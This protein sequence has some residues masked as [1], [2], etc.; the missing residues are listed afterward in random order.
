MSILWQSSAKAVREVCKLHR[1]GHRSLRTYPGRQAGADA[2]KEARASGISLYLLRKVRA[3]ADPKRGYAAEELIDLCNSIHFCWG[4]F[5]D[6]GASFGRTHVLRLVGVPKAGGRRA[7]IQ[8]AMFENG[9]STAE[10][11]NEV[12]RRYGRRGQGGRKGAIGTQVAGL[13]IRLD[14]LCQSWLRFNEQLAARKE[15][16]QRPA[17]AE[18]PSKVRSSV[19]SI[20]DNMRRLRKELNAC[21]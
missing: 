6:N 3:F 9:W 5:V 4:A 2:A 1:I 20:T 14:R 21:E 15:L 16:G 10:L 17:F 18:L 11:E 19:S 7:S 13:L 8:K 12:F